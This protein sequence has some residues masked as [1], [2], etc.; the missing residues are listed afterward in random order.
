MSIREEIDS[1]YPVR[2]SAEQ[3]RAFEQWVL[4]KMREMGYRPYVDGMNRKDKVR[5]R[6]IV[7]GDPQHAGIIISAHYDTA[8][9]IGI[10]DIRIPRNFPVYALSQLVILLALLLISLLVG[11]AVGLLSKNGD[12]LILSFFLTFL[13]IVLLMMFG[14]ANPHNANDNT[15]GVAALLETMARLSPEARES[16]AFILFDNQETGSRGAKYFTQQH[17][18]IQAMQLLVDLNCIGDGDHFIV[19]APKLAQD[20]PGYAVLRDAL[21]QNAAE[22]G[23]Q[24]GF[25]SRIRV[26]GAGDYRK[27]SCGVGISAYHHSTGVGLVTGRLHTSRDTVC[28]EENVAYLAKSLSETAERQIPPQEEEPQSPEENA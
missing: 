23:V 3:K 13:C 7:A 24:T 14:K 12:W 5:Q 8:A 26:R 6:N 20:K 28:R 10:P 18:E 11:C 25:W 19:S 9:T 22:F 2:K 17:V 1:L 27:F 4:A 15:S 21:E 16:T